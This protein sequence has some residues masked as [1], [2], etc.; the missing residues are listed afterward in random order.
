MSRVFDSRMCP[1]VFREMKERLNFEVIAQSV[2]TN[3]IK[4]HM[5]H[6]A[7]AKQ[8]CESPRLFQ[9]DL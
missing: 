5:Y 8:P 9:I 2:E 1:E 6:H 4:E 3:R 7:A